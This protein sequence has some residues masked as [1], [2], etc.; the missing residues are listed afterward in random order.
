MIRPAP[1]DPLP[2]KAGRLHWAAWP[3]MPGEEAVLKGRRYL[4]RPVK[5]PLEFTPWDPRCIIFG[6]ATDISLDRKSV[7]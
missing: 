2:E 4:R 6:F 3:R 7:V 5:T 1:P